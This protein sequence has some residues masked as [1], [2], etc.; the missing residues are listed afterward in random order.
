M[1]TDFRHHR[2]DPQS[3][4]AILH[5]VLPSIWKAAGRAR[6]PCS[7]RAMKYSFSQQA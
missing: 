2:T 6:G 3:G 7:V 1:R 5:S 4:A